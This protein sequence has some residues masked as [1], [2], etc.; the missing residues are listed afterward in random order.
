M[1]FAVKLRAAASDL[2]LGSYHGGYLALH[3]ITHSRVFKLK[4][5]PHARLGCLCRS[6]GRFVL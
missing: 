2:F 3:G 4:S 5:E 6:P 1:I